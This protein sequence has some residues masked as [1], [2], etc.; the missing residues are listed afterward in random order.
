MFSIDLQLV[1]K[2]RDAHRFRSG[3]AISHILYVDD[4][5]LYATIER[6]IDSA[7]HIIRIC[8]EDIRISFGL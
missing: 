3:V 8:C 2:S 4:L 5:S 7:I 1:V 6:G